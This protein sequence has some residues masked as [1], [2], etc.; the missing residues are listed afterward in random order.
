MKLDSISPGVWV[1]DH[2][3]LFAS[4]RQ[5]PSK[6]AWTVLAVGVID[7]GTVRISTT[8]PTLHEAKEHLAKIVEGQ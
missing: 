6:R 7:G 5:K 2:E 8:V 3:S 4:I 1:L